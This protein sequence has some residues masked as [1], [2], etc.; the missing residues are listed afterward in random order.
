MSFQRAL[1]ISLPLF[2]FFIYALFLSQ[3][4]NLVTAD[5]GRHIQNGAQ[6]FNTGHIPDTNFYSYTYNDYK[7]LNH[8][9]LSGIVFFLI[10][11]RS[12][13]LNKLKPKVNS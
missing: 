11:N 9:W 8:H 4:L 7:T 2:L 5:L 1:N 13:N 3:P 10:W 12:I 6:F